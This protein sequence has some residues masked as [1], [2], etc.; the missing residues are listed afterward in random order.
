MQQY[1]QAIRV[2][3]DECDPMGFV[4]H[5]HYLKYLEI[6]RTEMYRARGATY[7]DFEASGLFVVVV[8][9]E[10]QYRLPARYDDMLSIHVS[11]ERMTEAKIIHSYSVDRDTQQLATAQVTLAVIDRSGRPQRIPECLRS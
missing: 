9:V 8:R 11:V 2:R 6:A 4:H 10:C 5:S 7:R 1:T 3:Y